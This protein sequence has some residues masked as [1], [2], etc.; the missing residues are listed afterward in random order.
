MEKYK[1][2]ITKA[3]E[4]LTDKEYLNTFISDMHLFQPD[5][6]WGI[7][8]AKDGMYFAISNV[9]SK[10]LGFKNINHA[11]GNT[12]YD[13]KCKANDSAH[14][15]H[16]QDINV[17]Q[18][19]IGNQIL[20]IH[21]LAIGLCTLKT[22]KSPVMNPLTN[23]I[24]RVFW[25]CN[26]LELNA[27]LKTILSIHGTRFGKQQSMDILSNSGKF[28]LTK[29]ERDVLFCVCLGINNRKDVANFLSVIYKRTI[30]AETTVHDAF[31]RL[32][33]KLNCNTPM[34]LLEFAVY[35]D[36]HLQIPQA[37]LPT[38]SYIMR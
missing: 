35:N 22:T 20:D 7:N 33:R 25:Y 32:Y 11:L 2:L 21:E 23:N 16:Q 34:Q 4:P 27:P 19:K 12:Y 6:F 15:F 5:E 38:G 8:N 18:T 9:A 26:N 3:Q 1:Q 30:N 28:E 31:R 17:K 13:L 10:K 14:L 29:I 36:L 37:F 24:L